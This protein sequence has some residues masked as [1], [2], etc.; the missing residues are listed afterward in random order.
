MVPRLIADPGL[1]LERDLAS[2]GLRYVGGMD[3]VGRGALAGPASVGLVVVD[4]AALDSADSSAWHGV[5]DSKALTAKKR[6]ALAPAIGSWA[7]ACTVGH[8]Q[9]SRRS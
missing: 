8:A 1:D 6:E 2:Q 7:A 4:A 3:E 5:R 9:P